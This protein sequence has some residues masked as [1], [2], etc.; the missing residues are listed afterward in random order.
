DAVTAIPETFRAFV[1]E[2]TGDAVERGVREFMAADLPAGEVDVRVDWSSVNYKDALATIAT[3]KVARISPLIP[4]ID[5]A[6]EVV[7]S[8]DES[9]SAGTGVLAHGYDLGVA[10]HG[11][12]GAYARLPAGYV[13]P[14]PEGLS[15]VEAMT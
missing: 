3:G 4:G 9:V 5:L 15:A 10:R 7:A 8:T 1:A 6:G 2:G 12:Y 11:G 13:V 14:L